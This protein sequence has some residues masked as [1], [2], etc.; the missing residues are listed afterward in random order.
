MNKWSPFSRYCTSVRFQAYRI[1]DFFLSISVQHLNQNIFLTCVHFFG[2]YT[3][4]SLSI[5]PKHQAV[6]TFYRQL[7]YFNLYPNQKI[8]LHFV[9]NWTFWRLWNKKNSSL[10]ISPFENISF[11][12]DQFSATVH[13]ISRGLSICARVY[14][15]GCAKCAWLNK[16]KFMTSS[17][18]LVNAI[19][20]SNRKRE[21]KRP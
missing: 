11:F 2:S 16:S 5:A 7:L 13:L 17:L 3:L 14:P 9:A 1:K 12:L 15:G 18:M 6:S 21:R 20:S 8:T 19:A 4:T 10:Y